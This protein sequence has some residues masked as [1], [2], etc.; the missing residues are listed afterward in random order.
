VEIITE[1]INFDE[2][3]RS[4]IAANYQQC[5]T[6]VCLLITRGELPQILIIVYPKAMQQR[7]SHP[8]AF[9]LRTS[10]AAAEI[11]YYNVQLLKLITPLRSCAYT[12]SSPE[13]WR[14]SARAHIKRVM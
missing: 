5:E 3:E 7:G 9:S 8:R 14:C 11:N 10:H 1:I 6:V 2:N 4:P 13:M 12:N